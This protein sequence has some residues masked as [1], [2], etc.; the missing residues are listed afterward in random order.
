LKSSKPPN[1]GE[2]IVGVENGKEEATATGVGGGSQKERSELTW[3]SNMWGQRHVSKNHL[4]QPTNPS[5]GVLNVRFVKFV[6]VEYLVLRLG[7]E[8]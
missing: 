6:G 7:V 5:G 1:R 3:L 2:E 8:T 4:K